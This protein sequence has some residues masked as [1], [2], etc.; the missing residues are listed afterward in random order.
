M[1]ATPSSC[2]CSGR[3]QESCSS[4]SSRQPPRFAR[5]V[6]EFTVLG[7]GAAVPSKYRNVTGVWAHT[8][9]TYLLGPAAVSRKSRAFTDMALVFL[10]ALSAVHLQTHAGSSGAH[11]GRLAI[12]EEVI[13]FHEHRHGTHLAEL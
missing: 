10:S 8:A 3:D 4:S 9:A 7:T 6:A 2:M 11:V 12:K 13:A 5:S 1:L